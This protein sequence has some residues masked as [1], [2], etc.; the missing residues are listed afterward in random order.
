M[1]WHTPAR[2]LPAHRVGRH[3]ARDN[4]RRAVCPDRRRARKV[5][6]LP[7]WAACARAAPRRVRC[8]HCSGKDAR[9]PGHGAAPR[10]RAA[11]RRAPN[12][13]ARSADAC[14]PGLAAWITRSSSWMSAAAHVA[15]TSFCPRLPRR[16]A[17]SCSGIVHLRERLLPTCP[18]R[19]ATG[20]WRQASSEA[21]RTLQTR[22]SALKTSVLRA[23]W[24]HVASRASGRPS[25]ALRSIPTAPAAC[26]ASAQSVECAHPPPAVCVSAPPLCTERLLC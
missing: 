6:E 4:F 5:R 26:R 13:T 19:S 9:G 16:C 12:P 25:Y 24:R 8:A 10:T 22:A 21:G 1:T 2:T 20:C 7:C 11:L 14:P 15:R 17:A 18:C 23:S 3:A